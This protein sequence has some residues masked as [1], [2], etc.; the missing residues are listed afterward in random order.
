MQ[1]RCFH[2]HL[3]QLQTVA[4]C[5]H[6][7]RGAALAFGRCSSQCCAPGIAI[8]PRQRDP[9]AQS[10]RRRSATG[11]TD[12]DAAIG[13][14]PVSTHQQATHHLTQRDA[15]I[16][17]TGHRLA[18]FDAQRQR[19][20]RRFFQGLRPGRNRP[21]QIRRHQHI[22]TP[23]L[24]DDVAL[25]LRGSTDPIEQGP[26][27]MPADLA[28]IGFAGSL[29]QNLATVFARFAADLHPDRT[30][31]CAPVDFLGSD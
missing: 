24:N 18:A 9:H 6:R 13:P 26:G 31:K 12:I 25:P 22:G 14:T 4:V 28:Q 5:G 21:Q 30:S 1:L 17:L 23:F 19:G 27:K 2:L 8:D 20:I 29:D 11:T 15:V 7:C 10:A 16:F 3:R